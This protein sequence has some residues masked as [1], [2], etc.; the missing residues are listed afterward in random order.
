MK[1]MLIAGAL[2]LGLP[3]VASAQYNQSNF[4][5]PSRYANAYAS[6]GYDTDF[7]QNFLYAVGQKDVNK[8]NHLDLGTVVCSGD[9]VLSE[10]EKAYKKFNGTIGSSKFKGCLYV[11]DN[12]YVAYVNDSDA[13]T[14]HI[15]LQFIMTDQPAWRDSFY[16]GNKGSFAVYDGVTSKEF[17]NTT[18]FDDFLVKDKKRVAE[19]QERVMWVNGM[20]DSNG[21]YPSFEKSKKKG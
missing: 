13:D 5:L 14:G 20:P 18:K 12:N 6:Y 9:A 21:V 11:S 4:N 7:N 10:F 3:L 15:K 17:M 2:V 19:H 1:K 8:I 16:K